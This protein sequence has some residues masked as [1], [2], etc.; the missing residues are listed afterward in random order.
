MRARAA[1]R[2]WLEQ[3]RLCTLR[4]IA[5]GRLLVKGRTATGIGLGVLLGAAMGVGSYTFFYAR[6]ASYMTNDPRACANCH[7][8]DSYYSGWAKGS[9]HAVAVCNDCHAP[10]DLVGKYTTKGVNGFN[11]SWAFTTGWFKEP[12]EMTARNREITEGACRHCHQE[13]VQAIDTPH[14]GG[15]LMSCTRCHPSVGHMR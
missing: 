13:I 5:E 7:V 8:M 11:H 14:H 12:I 3:A 2:G 6:G 4:R 15:E 1:S 9:H 10:H